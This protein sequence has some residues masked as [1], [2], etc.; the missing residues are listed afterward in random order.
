MTLSLNY[1]FCLIP[2][3][4]NKSIINYGEYFDFIIKNH[5]TGYHNSTD[6]IAKTLMLMRNLILF[7]K[8]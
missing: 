7:Q 1:L 6:A 3:F 5:P 2:D 4:I 8:L